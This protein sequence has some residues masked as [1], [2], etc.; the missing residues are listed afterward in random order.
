MASFY[1]LPKTRVDSFRRNSRVFFCPRNS[2]LPQSYI[3]IPQSTIVFDGTCNV[4]IFNR[5]RPKVIDARE[6]SPYFLLR[7]ILCFIRIT[8]NYRSL[9]YFFFLS[10]PKNN[11]GLLNLKVSLVYSF[12]RRWH[13]KC[14]LSFENSPFAFLSVEMCTL[15][16]HTRTYIHIIYASICVSVCVVVLSTLSYIVRYA[17]ACVQ[18]NNNIIIFCWRP[19][20]ISTVENLPEQY[21]RP[22]ANVLRI[23]IPTLTSIYPEKNTFSR[24]FILTPPPPSTIVYFAIHSL[25]RALGTR[26]LTTVVFQYNHTRVCISD[27]RTPRNTRCD[28]YHKEISS[29]DRRKRWAPDGCRPTNIKTIPTRSV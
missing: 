6:Y 12:L 26:H 7:T 18:R 2:A 23:K 17:L 10:F 24:V 5:S 1:T 19:R 9:L 13:V 27:I 3:H 28:E 4:W 15:S 14:S 21:L 29:S 22:P 25:N 16:T 8:P 20:R 11:I